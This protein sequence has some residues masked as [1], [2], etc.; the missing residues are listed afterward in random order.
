MQPKPVPPPFL[1]CALQIQPGNFT[2]VEDIE[3]ELKSRI[4]LA[5]LGGAEAY[6]SDEDEMPRGGQRVQ[7]AQQ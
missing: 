7:C 6:D 2:T 3:S 4:H 1:P 5:K